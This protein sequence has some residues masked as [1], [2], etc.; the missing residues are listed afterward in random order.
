MHCVVTKQM[1]V[2]DF[3]CGGSILILIYQKCCL[4]VLSTI[5]P[6]NMEE[7]EKHAEH[8]RDFHVF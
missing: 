1:L 5:Y 3:L 8:I 7:Q 4:C 2:R 6:D